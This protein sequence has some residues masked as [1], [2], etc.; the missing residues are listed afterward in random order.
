MGLGQLIKHEYKHIGFR[1]ASTTSLQY[2]CA[3]QLICS[4][5]YM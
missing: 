1:K 2:F 4:Q 5:L 3:R